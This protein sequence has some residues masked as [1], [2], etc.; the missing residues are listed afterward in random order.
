[1]WAGW[2][3]RPGS[4]LPTLPTDLARPVARSQD[5]VPIVSDGS[6]GPHAGRL[7]LLRGI[8]GTF[9]P[10]VLTALMGASGAGKTVRRA[11]RILRLL[12]KTCTD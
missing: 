11:L 10:G 12:C 1:M 5:V 3:W 8:S 6:G 9:R 4:S 2:L 7:L